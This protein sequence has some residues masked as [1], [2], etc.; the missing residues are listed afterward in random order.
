V[1]VRAQNDAVVTVFDD[2]GGPPNIHGESRGLK[3]R[4]NL[5][6]MTATRI[7][8]DLHSPRLLAQYEGN[9]DELPNGDDLIGWGEQPYFSE[10]TNRGQPVFD[11]RLGD[12]NPV[13]RVYKFRWTGL[14]LT[15]PGLA[16]TLHNGVEMAYASWN[17][18]TSVHSWRVL[19]G[20][21]TDALATIATAANK[22]FE[23]AIKIR[24]EA[25]V[26]V[27]ALDSSGH[28][29]GTSQPERPQ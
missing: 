6:Q 8:R 11:A 28:V 14:P 15:P 18:A 10:Y 20:A 16:V 22:N 1:R 21:S 26:E 9:D 27:Q 19:G 5:K 29:L 7:V 24:P 25:Y 4:L 2:G 3:L 23:T 13:Y 17:G 12:A